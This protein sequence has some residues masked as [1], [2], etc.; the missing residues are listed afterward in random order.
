M[1][2][3]KIFKIII[4]LAIFFLPYL[5]LAEILPNYKY[6]NKPLPIIK[7]KD[8]DDAV[9]DLLNLETLLPSKYK[10]VFKYSPPP[11]K[12]KILKS[13]LYIFIFFDAEKD[14]RIIEY[15]RR[16]EK[17]IMSNRKNKII[18]ILINT[19]TNLSLNDLRKK[20]I[21]IENPDNGI[22]VLNGSSIYNVMFQIKKYRP[23]V[24]ISTYNSKIKPEVEK[25]TSKLVV[26]K[27]L[28]NDFTFDDFI[29]AINSVLEKYQ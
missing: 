3:G 29:D 11:K 16:Y 4:S 21:D 14:K 28:A 10:K 5:S 12:D 2:A 20:V 17:D 8:V 13:F 9:I 27:A 23:L 6:I 25:P 15:V 7:G 18:I 26:R 22:Y 1:E 24:L 19:N